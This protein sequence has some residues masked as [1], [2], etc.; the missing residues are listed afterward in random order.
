[1]VIN[2]IVGVYIPIIRIPIKGGMTI[3]NIATG[4]NSSPPS[5]ELGCPGAA[6]EGSSFTAMAMSPILFS[7]LLD[8]EILSGASIYD[9]KGCILVNDIQV[10]D[11]DR[12]WGKICESPF[13]SLRHL[14]QTNFQGYKHSGQEVLID[15]SPYL[16]EHLVQS[17]TMLLFDYELTA[18]RGD[19]PTQALH[20]RPTT[21]IFVVPWERKQQST[22]WMIDLFAGGYGGWSYAMKFL[23]E[24]LQQYSMLTEFEKH[25]IIAIEQDTPAAA[26]HAHNH[27]M[28]LLP[29]EI[30]PHDWF[31]Q[32][33]TSSVINAPI[34]SPRWKQ[35][36]AIVTPE[37]WT[38]SHPCQSW[39]NAAHSKGFEDTNGL[40]FATALGL[41][42]IYRPKHVALEN[43]KHFQDHCQFPL[44]QALIRWAG[45]RVLHQ[46]IYDASQQLPVK[47]PRYLAILQRVEDSEDQFQWKSWKTIPNITPNIWDAWTPTSPEEFRQFTLAPEAQMMY[48]NPKLLPTGF[49]EQYHQ[50]MMKF[51]IPPSN[52]KLPVFMAAYGSHHHLPFQLLKEKGMHGFFT[53]EN[54]IIRW[55]KPEEILLL[56][57]HPFSCTLLKPAELSWK[58]LGNSIVLHHSILALANILRYKQGFS[59]E[60][61]FPTIFQTLD[62]RRLRAAT[63][64]YFSDEFAWYVGQRNQIQL[65]RQQIHF[66]AKEMQWLGKS[67]PTWPGGVFFHPTHGLQKF[68]PPPTP[69]TSLSVPLTIEDSSENEDS[70]PK[71]SNH[72][73]D[74]TIAA[75]PG[76]YGTLKID[77]LWQWTDLFDL[78]GDKLQPHTTDGFPLKLQSI[79]P[80]AFLMPTK[81]EVIITQPETDRYCVL[82]DDGHD[83]HCIP[84]VNG[85]QW[86]D[87]QRDH[88][89]LTDFLYDDFGKI[90]PTMTMQNSMKVSV[91]PIMVQP[92]P[93]IHEAISAFEA[94]D[95]MAMIPGNTD[96]LVVIFT[97]PADDLI[98]VLTF[99]HYALNDHWLHHHSRQMCFQ[100]ETPTK[101]RLIFRPEGS[102]FATPIAILQRSIQAQLLKTVFASYHSKEDM[103][104]IQ[105]HFEHR[106]ISEISLPREQ[107]F[108][109]FHQLCQHMTLFSN[110]GNTPAILVG[111]KRIGDT[112]TV[113][114]L[115]DHHGQNIKC[116]IGQTLIGG[117]N[118]NDHKQSI[119]AALAS[120]LIEHG[121]KLGEVSTHVQKIM[122][123]IGIPKLTQTLFVATDPEQTEQIQNILTECDIPVHGK[124]AKIATSK[125]KYTKIALDQQMKQSRQIDVHHYKLMPGFFIRADGTSLPIQATFSPCIS[126]VT[127]MPT[128]NAEQ[129]LQHK[130]K[131]IPEEMAIF[132]IGDLTEEQ[133]QKTQKVVA[134]AY[135]TNGDQ[136]LLAGWLLQL[137]ETQVHFANQDTP[138]IQTLDVQ[139]CSI[140]LWSEDFTKEQWQE[141]LKSPVKQTKLILDKDQLGDVIKNPWGRTYRQGKNPC[142]QSDAT[143]VQFH[144]EIIIKDLRKLLHRSG[145]N[146]VFVTPKDAGGAPS[147]D[148]RII[149]TSAIPTALEAQTMSQPGAAGLIKGHKNY[150]L[151]VEQSAFT[152]I[153]NLLHPGEEPPKQ[154]PKGTLWRLHPLPY[155]VD[156]QV[157]QEWADNVGWSCFPIRPLGAKAW[158][159]QSQDL[160]P[161]TLLSF[162]G[163]PLIIKSM[164]SKAENLTTGLIAG[165]KSKPVQ[166]S[167]PAPANIFRTGDPYHDAWAAWQPTANPVGKTTPM[168]QEGIPGPTTA[169]LQQH[170]QQLQ[171]LE[172]AVKQLE[173]A[174]RQKDTKDTAKFADIEDSI[175]QN[176]QQMQGA[177]HS[178]RSDFQT[179][180]AHAIT[181]QDA[182]LSKGFEELKDLFRQR[183]KR[184][185]PEK[186][187]DMESSE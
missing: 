132:L 121:V 131:I 54:G 140:T 141:I 167:S 46:G 152:Q 63:S 138:K 126:G 139:V 60:N 44:V 136:V 130:G 98:R 151:R 75:S 163:Q 159:M 142:A 166:E 149:W 134:P 53:K 148:W 61:D 96:I 48:L 171:T 78:W 79:P 144:T 168:Q 22:P 175:Q 87:A 123:Q 155:G 69:R 19:F 24:E 17:T 114:E 172:S 6:N 31:C 21:N 70:H 2:P 71:D 33:P 5:G 73:C 173:E 14:D 74:I 165:P 135:N 156:K 120:V 153:W 158:L 91:E 25:H 89:Q 80:K 128:A 102:S 52:Q 40:A 105:V 66:L 51:R 101:A 154:I 162:N 174:H 109:D 15:I 150:G 56:H 42:R 92:F 43:V 34:Q 72:A 113:G 147:Q 115:V 187:E 59:D 157:M 64:M 85:I 36:V 180:L 7:H 1:M 125:A 186:A 118:K 77:G 82:W 182:K 84:F 23:T 179:S 170:D 13:G 112:I 16:L 83:S 41:I 67:N 11:D 146:K 145:F 30:L 184:R 164:P 97:G 177:F 90:P 103:N 55:F 106:C 20:M 129:W 161:K 62:S 178:L 47:R 183:E 68:E 137:G 38:I 29:D 8:Y 185:K 37:L 117:A 28:I 58:F 35:P 9:R 94:I 110:Q 18:G 133:Q 124:T 65:K 10:F 3:P 169:H 93:D 86:K 95:T 107:T 143:S 88:P 4:L 119:Q 27:D 81:S 57:A 122:Q 160:P 99:W 39:T 49:S 181:Q 50:D 26:S 116:V 127:M 76:T 32:H 176:H 100:V 45:Y 108:A 111:M 104:F 12:I